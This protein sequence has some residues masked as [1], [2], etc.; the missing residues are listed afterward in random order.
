[1]H[2]SVVLQDIFWKYV[3]QATKE[4]QVEDEQD[5]FGV[6]SKLTLPFLLDDSVSD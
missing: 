1:M 3:A 2:V 5:W 4:Q 6:A